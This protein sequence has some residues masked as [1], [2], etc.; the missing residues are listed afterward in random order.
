MKGADCLVLHKDTF[1][2]VEEVLKRAMLYKFIVDTQTEVIMGETEQ[3]QR[4]AD[5]V[6]QRIKFIELI[7]QAVNL[8][9]IPE[10]QLVTE[11]YLVIGSEY[12]KDYDVYRDIM[13]ISNMTY[14]K[15]R[16]Q[17]FERLAEALLPVKIHNS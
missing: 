5:G 12:L 8:L 9:P 10:K 2:A 4:Y 7:E 13:Q 15:I 14:S 11:R 1:K 6:Q 16:A 17:A 3:G